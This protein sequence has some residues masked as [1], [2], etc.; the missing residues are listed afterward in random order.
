MD[1]GHK[2]RDDNRIGVGTT[3]IGSIRPVNTTLLLQLIVNGVIVGALY[4]VVAEKYVD[5]IEAIYAG[6]TE[7][8]IDTEI[9]FQDGSR[10]RIR[11]TMPIATLETPVAA[12]RSA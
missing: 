3:S 12:K 2:A 9:A 5:I 6:K 11:T 7:V 1:P 10:Q 4:G 8:K